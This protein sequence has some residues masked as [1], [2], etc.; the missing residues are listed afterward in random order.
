MNVFF[1]RHGFSIANATHYGI[2]PD[3]Q[4]DLYDCELTKTGI[5][6]SIEIGRTFDKKIDYIFCSTMTRAIQTAYF[7]FLGQ[8]I[9]IINHIKEIN[10]NFLRQ[11]IKKLR[12]IQKTCPNIH[13]NAECLFTRDASST[14]FNQFLKF[15]DHI[16]GAKNIVVVTHSM[17]MHKNLNIEIPNNNSIYQFRYENQNLTFVKKINNGHIF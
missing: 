10:D 12:Q 13:L 2:Y 9:N 15:L 11:P 4:S 6:K 3:V 5:Q 17:Y 1:I 7:M 14:D 8:P 16:E